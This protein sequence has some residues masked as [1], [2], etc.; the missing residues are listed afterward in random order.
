MYY[1]GQV[2]FFSFWGKEKDVELRISEILMFTQLVCRT[3]KMQL[4]LSGSDL[5]VFL[6]TLYSVITVC[7]NKMISLSMLFYVFL[8]MPIHFLSF[9]DMVGYMWV[10]NN[11][12]GQ[13]LKYQ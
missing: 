4:P 1:A 12:Q 3:E 2:L 8:H 13:M 5:S 9:G 11:C 6:T 10:G 7:K